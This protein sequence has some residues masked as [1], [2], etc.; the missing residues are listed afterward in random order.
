[1]QLFY[2]DIPSAQST[3][4]ELEKQDSRHLTK[5]LRKKSGDTFHVT[6]GKGNLFDA[7]LGLVT[8]NRCEIDLA[9][10]KAEPPPSP[11]LHIAIAPTKMNDRM[12]WF[13]EKAT[14]IGVSTISP[15]ICQRSERKKI[16]HDRF[17]RI[18]TS[19]LQQSAQLW[20]P[21]LKD[22]QSF[23]QF[24]KNHDAQQKFMAHCMDGTEGYLGSQLEMGSDTI[25]M[26]GPEGDFTPDEWKMAITMGFE[27][28]NLG[29]T[30]LRTETA[31][32]YTATI[33]Q[34]LQLLDLK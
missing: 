30:R 13:L 27:S 31:G 14:E 17:Q 26:I 10:A 33:F 4:L 6:D 34:G 21:E 28:V 23:D 3:K 29:N 7:T 32:V 16:N 25:I 11:S 22:Q 1:M 15:I 9:F 20:M 8:S 19:A 18:I 12:E 5:V 24:V 2:Y